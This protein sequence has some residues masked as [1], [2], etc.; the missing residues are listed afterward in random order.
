MERPKKVTSSSRSISA[1]SLKDRLSALT[2]LKPITD[3]LNANI[4]FVPVRVPRKRRLQTLAVAVWS[5]LIALTLVLYLLLWSIPPLWPFLTI[6]FIW[7]RWI[8]QSPE[9]GGRT[10]QWFRKLSFWR[11]FADYYPASILKEADLPADRPYV[12]GYHPHGI[13]G[14]GALTTFATEATGFSTAFP[15]IKPHLLTLAS[16]FKMPIYRD[17]LLAMGICSVSKQSCSNILKAG[18]GSAITIVVGGAAESLSARPGTADL[19]LRK[20]L[21][22]IKVAIQQG[23]DL[24]PVFSFGEN[25]IYE[26]MPNEKGTTVFAMQKK[27]QAM[28]GWTLPLFHGRGLLNCALPPNIVFVLLI[29]SLLSFLYPDNLGL[30]PYRRQIVVVVGKPIHIKQSDK[31]QIEDVIQVQKLYIDEL[32]RIWNSYKD[33]FAKART[34]ELNIVE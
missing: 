28:F 12:F 8:D 16:N 15:G 3:S 27:F 32:T 22:F 7:V 20:R 6:Y 13:I 5:T 33:Q 21:G 23:A 24:V 18:P 17:I 11:Y 26:Q 30:L 4:D 19:T 31:P 25:D 34:R 2:H 14:M 9:K 29:H 1:S 10:S